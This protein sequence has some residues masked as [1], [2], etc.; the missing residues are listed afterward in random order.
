M[1]EDGYEILYGDVES[2]QDSYQLPP[3]V[4]FDDAYE[5]G[6]ETTV[7][8]DILLDFFVLFEDAEEV[9][10]ELD[11][12]T[13]AL[14]PF[15]TIYHPRV[16]LHSFARPAVAGDTGQVIDIGYYVNFEAVPLV[17][18]N[19]VD[20]QFSDLTYGPKIVTWLWHF[21]DGKTSTEKN[22]KHSYSD[23]GTYTVILEVWSE[24]VEY[25]IEVK[26]NYITIYVTVE[27]DFMA[28]PLKFCAPSGV[29][30]RDRSKGTPVSWLWNFGDG[31][32][33]TEQHPIHYYR[34][35]GK[36][37]VSLYVTDGSDNSTLSLSDIIE[38]KCVMLNC[39]IDHI[40]GETD[41]REETEDL[42]FDLVRDWVHKDLCDT[43][44]RM[45]PLLRPFYREV[46]A[47]PVNLGEGIF[48][49]GINHA[50]EETTLTG[51]PGL[52]VNQYVN[53]SLLYVS[54]TTQYM[55]R[56]LSNTETEV[57]IERGASL[58]VISSGTV[59]MS[60]NNSGSYADLSSLNMMWYK[61]PLWLLTDG[62]GKQIERA[63]LEFAEDIDQVPQYDGQ[64]LYRIEGQK[65]MFLLG[66]GATLPGFVLVGYHRKPR[67]AEVG[68]D[69]ID[70]PAEFHNVPQLAT[71]SRVR[72]RVGDREEANSLMKRHDTVIRTLLARARVDEFIDK[73]FDGN[74]N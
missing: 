9:G 41:T 18:R 37:S 20:V 1:F 4:L 36:Y 38:A 13:D 32:T 31:E 58:P 64:V 8:E 69:C 63:P 24:D 48:I 61:D 7:G 27:A 12:G 46:S 54:G 17:Q 29:S 21:G 19:N 26:V 14:F 33:S 6:Y 44:Y 30:F 28:A 70:M 50:S 47:V 39:Y 56:V 3:V 16:T 74:L 2:G 45:S 11:V 43:L 10:Y 35:I 55:A 40:K 65:I 23:A 68:T 66:Y 42:P 51:F 53:G 62:S 34:E 22:P 71:M 15:I 60:T 72:A 5:V 25:A 73:T 67:K 59:L 57:T 52:T 49:F